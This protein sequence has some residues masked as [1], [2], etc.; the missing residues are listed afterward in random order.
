MREPEHFLF[1]VESVVSCRC[2][3]NGG[4]LYSEI[5]QSS[6]QRE[7]VRWCGAAFGATESQPGEILPGLCSADAPEAIVLK[8]CPEERYLQTT[9]VNR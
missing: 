3:P 5:I 6:G 1:A 8:G 9:D 4:A 2:S 7:A